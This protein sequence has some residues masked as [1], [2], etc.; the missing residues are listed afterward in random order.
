MGVLR[1]TVA[2]HLK[3]PADDI[4]DLAPDTT[5]VDRPANDAPP[6]A[7]RHATDVLSLLDVLPT[8]ERAVFTARVFDELPWAEVAR[9]TGVAVHVVEYRFRKAAERLRAA[10]MRRGLGPIA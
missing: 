4:V 3:A 1:R 2:N 5:F 8:E 10:A 9:A 7:R 6:D